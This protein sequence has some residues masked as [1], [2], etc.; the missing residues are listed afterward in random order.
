VVM[1]LLNLME[2]SVSIFFFYPNEK[3]NQFFI[4][5]FLRFQLGICVLSFFFFSVFECDCVYGFRFRTK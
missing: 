1:L 3:K 5:A 2:G 4:M